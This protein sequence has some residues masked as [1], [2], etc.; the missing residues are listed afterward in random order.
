LTSLALRLVYDSR[1]QESIEATVR[2]DGGAEGVAGAPS[3][4]S[5]SA[6][7]V[8][9]FPEGGVAAALAQRRAI[10][11]AISGI[12]LVDQAAVDAALHAVDGTRDFS[13]IGGNTAT[14]ISVATA[15]ARAHAEGRPLAEVVRRPGAPAG[16][17]PAIVGNCL[18]G[19]RHAIGGPDI[20]EFLA[21]APEARPD[22][23]VRAA[24]AVHRAVGKALHERL[25]KAALGRGD[26]GGWVAGV[27]N[28]EALEILV[29]A[30]RH[31]TEELGLKVRPGLDLAASEFFRDGRYRYREQTL[32]AEGQ[33]GFVTHLVEHFD[34]A[35]VEDP[36]DEEDFESFARLTEAVGARTLVVGDDIYATDRERVARGT[37]MRATNAVLIKVNQV[38]TLSDALATVD[39]ARAEGQSTVTSHRS[40]ELPEGWLA[41][42]AVG[43]GSAGLKCGLLGGE[44]VAKLNE[45]R[46]LGAATG[47]AHGT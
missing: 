41:H 19:G 31:A 25:P 7:E 32:D 23:A 43:F 22:D 12:E 3:G 24:L 28:L 17:F 13:R 33:L 6:H 29:S 9:A 10:E 42:L 27:S 2:A 36:F 30:C 40:G 34:L 35:Y 20:Q 16:R 38:G 5:T 44:R 15:L 18:N 37:A 11:A 4:A 8:R 47:S 1:G 26:E 21:F 46:R 14:A 39:L 45:L